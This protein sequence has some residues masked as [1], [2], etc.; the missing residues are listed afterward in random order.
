MKAPKK[1]RRDETSEVVSICH[2]P[3]YS[4]CTHLLFFGDKINIPFVILCIVLELF[5]MRLMKIMTYTDFDEATSIVC[6]SFK[7]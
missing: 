2:T 3:F 6:L 5:N 1:E 4:L 7:L